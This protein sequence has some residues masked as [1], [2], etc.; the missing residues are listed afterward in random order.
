MSPTA[1]SNMGTG[2]FIPEREK[3]PVPF[4][5]RRTVALIT[6]I[7]FITTS[8]PVDM[9]RAAGT[10]SELPGGGSDRAGGAGVLKELRVDTFSLPASLGHIRDSWSSANDPTIQRSSHPTIIHIQDAH[11]NYAAQRKISDII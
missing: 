6:L 11:C 3:Q 1:R 8:L 2:Y 7:A 10:P 4:L 5:F 9:A